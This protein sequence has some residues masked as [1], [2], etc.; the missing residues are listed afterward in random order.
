MKRLV[1]RFYKTMS[2]EEPVRDWLSKMDS[3][4]RKTIGIDIALVEFGWPSNLPKH[5][6][7]DSGMMRLISSVR[8]GTAEARMYFAV[9]AETMLLLHGEC[10]EARGEHVAGDRLRDH[11]RRDLRPAE[12]KEV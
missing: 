1:A 3:L 12:N 11:Q 6:V 10:G 5:D 4:D 8:D 7:L 9:H 2:G